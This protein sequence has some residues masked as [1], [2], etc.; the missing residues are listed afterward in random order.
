MPKALGEKDSTIHNL[1]RCKTFGAF[2]RNIGP[3]NPLDLIPRM[4]ESPA[5]WEA[6]ITFAETVM[7]RKEETGCAQNLSERGKSKSSFWCVRDVG[8]A[9][10]VVDRYVNAIPSL[11]G[12]H[13]HGLSRSALQEGH[14]RYYSCQSQSLMDVYAALLLSGTEVEFFFIYV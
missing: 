5:S 13:P 4:L 14:P 7:S 10:F 3:F 11:S 9:F 6:V 8:V 2:V 12:R 1:V